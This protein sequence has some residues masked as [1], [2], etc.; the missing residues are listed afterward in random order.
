MLSAV[1]QKLKQWVK[2]LFTKHIRKI[3][4]SQVGACW[5]LKN[6]RPSLTTKSKADDK[7]PL[8]EV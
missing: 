1:L 4:Q 3:A 8:D 2:G 7:L 5:K 6:A